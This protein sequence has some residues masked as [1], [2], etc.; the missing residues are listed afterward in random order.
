[1]P[2]ILQDTVVL[3]WERNVPQ[4]GC[5]KTFKGSG[6]RAWCSR[7]EQQPWCHAVLRD[8]ATQGTPMH[9]GTAPVHDSIWQGYCTAKYEGKNLG[10]TWQNT[11]RTK[12]R[13]ITIFWPSRKCELLLL[14]K[15]NISK[16]PLWVESS[17]LQHLQHW[18]DSLT[19]CL[20][21]R[22][23]KTQYLAHQIERMRKKPPKN[24][25]DRHLVRVNIRLHCGVLA[26]H[27]HVAL[28]VTPCLIH[29][30]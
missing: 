15:C 1:M 19:L 13:I 5:P 9:T 18:A 27:I 30:P 10:L 17:R 2:V 22:K 11:H 26:S 16:W 14:S 12:K 24:T 8:P 4:L 28:A 21:G 29:K 7:A 3:L 6:D 20:G 23:S 25:W